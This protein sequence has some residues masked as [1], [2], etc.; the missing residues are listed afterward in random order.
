M[1]AL[2]RIGASLDAG[3]F[4]VL[5]DT[6][7]ALWIVALLLFLIAYGPILW[8]ARLQSNGRNGSKAVA[9][10]LGGKG[11]LAVDNIHQVAGRITEKETAKSPRFR[12]RPV[13]HFCP[14]RANGRFCGIKIIYAD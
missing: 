10:G 9:A 4:A 7:G 14:R 5:L 1:G 6:G 8:T 12:G 2:L 3:P 13:H 11:G